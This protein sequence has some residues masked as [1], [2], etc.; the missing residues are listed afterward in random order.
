MTTAVAIAASPSAARA[1]SDDERAR[2]HFSAGR[3]Y[4][5]QG[6]YDEAAREF[7]EA[8]LLSDRPTLLLNEAT[9]LERALRFDEAVDRLEA[10]LEALPETDDRRTIERR[11]TELRERAD[12]LGP[13]DEAS[14]PS[15]GEAA[16]AIDLDDHQEAVSSQE[17]DTPRES[18]GGGLGPLGVTGVAL[19]GVGVAAGIGALVTG[20]SARSTHD[21]LE[22]QCDGRACPAGTGDQ[23]DEG[24]TMAIVSTVLTVVGIVAGGTGVTLLAVDLAGAGGDDAGRGTGQAAAATLAVVP[25]PGDIGLALE[26]RTF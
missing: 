17:G 4:F 24:R 14:A 15:P 20:L 19:T 13:S 10:Y 26:L 18:G 1:Q 23:I 7:R 21:D 12:A 25:G 8:Y 11:I 9:A 5:E 22:R 6:R 3:S 16:S 2:A